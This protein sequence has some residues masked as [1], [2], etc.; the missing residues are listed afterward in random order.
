MEYDVGVEDG[1]VRVCH[2]LNV[3][4]VGINMLEGV[5]ITS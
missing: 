3:G 2:G 5:D 1:G 4:G